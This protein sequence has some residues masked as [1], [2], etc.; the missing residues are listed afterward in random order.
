MLLPVLPV[1]VPGIHDE[2]SHLLLADTLAHGRLANP[3]H[4]MWIHFETFHVNQHPTYGSMYY[5]GQGAFL[6]LGQVVFRDPFWGVWVSNGLM[7]AAICWML[8]A[9]V[10]APWALLGGL[11]AVMRLT[12][13]SY[14][15]NTYFGGAVAALGGALVLGALP[16]I[17][18]RQ[19]VRDVVIM[20][21]GLIILANTRPYESLFFC[22]PVALSIGWWIFH[23]EVAPSLKLS[24]FITPLALVLIIGIGAIGY[25]FYRVTGSPFRIP[26][27]INISTYHL[28]YFP[29]QKLE[30]GATYHHEVMRRFYQ[31]PPVVGQYTHAHQE[32]LIWL[33]LKLLPLSIFYL[34]AVLTLPFLIAPFVKVRGHR[35]LFFSRKT[36]FL[37]TVC[38]ATLI[39]VLLPIYIP[40]A[41]YSAP[42]T[43][44]LYALLIQAMR[45]VRKWKWNGRSSGVFL[46]R[47]IPMICLALLP[48]RA[49]AH[50]LHIPVPVTMIHTWYTEDVH[51]LDRAQLVKQL[52]SQPGRHL[53]LVRYR[54]DHEILEEWV[55]NGADIDGSKIVWARDMGAQANQELIDYYPERKVWLIEPDEKPVRVTE[56]SRNAAD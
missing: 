56:Y 29:W 20:G 49:G 17:K 6:A 22:A 7:C 52:Q 10:P 2:L 42:M 53:V 31:G 50:A 12:A 54:P 16:R 4:P 28:V 26:Y 3:P 19:H 25:Y 45:V 55:Y 8:Q 46:V 39:A 13:F 14:W 5:P 43:S 32:P 36:K 18:R 1:P 24:H 37:L 47:A 38:G 33:A 21:L 44:A 27:Q 51:N 30:V 23:K 35:G 15:N 40:P 11:M 9:W 34:G 41:H 48:V